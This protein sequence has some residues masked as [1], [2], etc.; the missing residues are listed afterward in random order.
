VVRQSKQ[1]IVEPGLLFL[2][3]GL[4]I[5]L[6][7]ALWASGCDVGNLLRSRGSLR[8]NRMARARIIDELVNGNRDTPSAVRAEGVSDQKILFYCCSASCLKWFSS[9]PDN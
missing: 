5:A 9:S 3:D 8:E 4:H 2:L 7:R 1:R 6:T